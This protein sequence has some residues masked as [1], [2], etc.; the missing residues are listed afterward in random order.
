MVGGVAATLRRMSPRRLRL[1]STYDLTLR[2]GISR[3]AV[4]KVLAADPRFAAKAYRIRA[5]GGRFT[6]VFDQGDVERFEAR[7]GRRVVDAPSGES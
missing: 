6:L 2:W 1:L 5:D 4:H 3:Q 7:T